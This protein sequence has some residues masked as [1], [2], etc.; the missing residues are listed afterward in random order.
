MPSSM[1]R[2]CSS[3]ISANRSGAYPHLGR[4]HSGN[5][6]GRTGHQ[7]RG[8]DPDIAG[9]A[10]FP[11]DGP[12]SCLQAPDIKPKSILIVE[13]SFTSRTLLKNILEA[14]G[15]Q[16]S[17][18]I[19]GMDGLDQLKTGVFDAV[20]ADVEMPRMDGISLTREIRSDKELADIPSY[21]S[22]A[23]IPARTGKGAW[24]PARTPIL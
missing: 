2:K 18:A 17:T 16:V 5:R 24:K 10:P 9:S 8:S 4:H 13:D 21:W 11:R 22:P 14:T 15:Y 23:W 1:N 20:V 12:G 7:C 6:P 3:K 19:D